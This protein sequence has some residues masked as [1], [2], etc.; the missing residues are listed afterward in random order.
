MNKRHI[1]CLSAIVFFFTCSV[2]YAADDELKTEE[3]K[4]FYYMGTMIGVNIMR[5]DLTDEQLEGVIRGMRDSAKGEAIELD[6]A[7]YQPKLQELAEKQAASAAS[8]E[9]MA[10]TK[11]LEK[12]AAED[13]AIVTDSGI[14]I[15][16]LVAG[17]GNTPTVE[18]VVKAHYHGTLRDGT[19]FDSS[20]ERGQPFTA[21]LA[22]V[23]QCWQETITMMKEGGKSNITCPAAVAYG[24][25]AAGE[26]PAG[27]ALNFEVE[28][29][30]IEE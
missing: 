25:R 4:T 18:S 12:M 14:V 5:L 20:V 6:D 19:V 16:E 8:A 24:D 28:L 13:G 21:P 17:T 10:S 27:S 26:I 11:F 2:V 1:S 7:I 22:N 30:S 15:T 9:K 23:I 3:E 29:I